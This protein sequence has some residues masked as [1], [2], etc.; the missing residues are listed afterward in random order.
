MTE[1][2]IADEIFGECSE[3]IEGEAA[4]EEGEV[5]EEVKAEAEE[6]SENVSLLK[7]GVDG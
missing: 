3:G 6:A 2:E 7:R 1:L 4:A 5:A